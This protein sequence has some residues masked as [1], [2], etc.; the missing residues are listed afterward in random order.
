MSFHQSHV[1]QCLIRTSVYQIKRHLVTKLVTNY[2]LITRPSFPYFE[3]KT[4]CAL[5]K[6]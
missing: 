3:R 5:T 4:Y 1:V 2:V 6:V